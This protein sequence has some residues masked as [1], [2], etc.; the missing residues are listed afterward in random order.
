VSRRVA[1]AAAV[2]ALA[3]LWAVAAWF[4][5]RSEV[6]SSLHLPH[7]DTNALFPAAELHHADSYDRG[8]TILWVA[9]V[10]IALVVFTL[11]AW[12]GPRFVRE[13]AA[14]PVGTGM[15]LGMIGFALLWL[16][17]L[18]TTLA[19]VWWD[20]RYGVSNEGYLHSVLGGWAVL[21]A[22]FVGLCIAL[23]IV[24][25]LARRVGSWWWIPAAPVFVA[26]AAL[27]AFVAPYLEP[28]HRLTDPALVTAV[29]QLEARAGVGHVPV[30]VQD[31]SSD[32]S[33]PNADTE[34]LGPSRRVVLWNT[35]LD[36]R[37]TNGEVRVV[38]AH[39]LG[40]VK[41]DHIWKSVAWYA[42][43]ALPGAYLISRITRRR[44]GMGQP[45]A[46]PLA[47]LTLVVLGLLA[48]PI[49]N[50]ITRH[51]ESEAD[52]LALQTTHDPADAKTLFEKFVPTAL[53]NPNPPTWEYLLLEN[54]PTV[55]QRIAMVLAWEKRYATSTSPSAA[56]LP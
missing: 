21:G 22:S 37:F 48:L 18:P 51:M 43:F 16:A 39:E 11:Y 34:G 56:Q 45:E 12:R 49:Q 26:L 10:V 40:H 55:A 52:W 54:H 33:L 2:A 23:G 15:L 35:L 4:L 31:V 44:G 9:G 20:R 13:S 36:G 32:T 24:I 14:G 47:I 7:V 3:V 41:R 53:A 50:V 17:E 1:V 6:P 46:V 25:G 19:G 27:L 5:W 8:A 28:T 30:R 29:H 42:L 38:I